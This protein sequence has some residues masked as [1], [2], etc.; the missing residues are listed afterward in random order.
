MKILFVSYRAPPVRSARSTRLASIGRQLLSWGHEV[1]ILTVDMDGDDEV[2]RQKL[3]QAQFIR[4]QIGPIEKSRQATRK[5]QTSIR[6]EKSSG[7]FLPKLRQFALRLAFPDVQVEWV[8]SLFGD[9]G[10][11]EYDIVVSLVPPFS[12]GLVGDAIATRLW[13]PHVL[14]YGDPWSTGVGSR[15]KVRRRLEMTLERRVLHRARAVVSN[16]PAT[17]DLMQRSFGDLVELQCV[18]S[19]YDEDEYEQQPTALSSTLRHL[20]A[21]YDARLPFQPLEE[22]L[23]VQDSFESVEAY[24]DT[25]HRSLPR[26]LVAH[27]RVSYAASLKLMQSAQALLLIGNEGGLQIPSKLYAYLGSRRPILAVL[28]NLKDPIASLDVGP[29]LLCVENRTSEIVRGLEEISR[30]SE[31]SYVPPSQFSWTHRA[32]EFEN[33]LARWC[34]AT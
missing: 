32:R 8:R 20:G 29:Q 23:S 30:R 3:Q 22:A 11:G 27:D 2:A 28:E 16:S 15:S 4:T 21:I 12:G 17:V 18:L 25:F 13:V 19:G 6:S 34:D 31:N 10:L 26:S 33:H 7:T 5:L 14:D 24:G 1:T 9:L